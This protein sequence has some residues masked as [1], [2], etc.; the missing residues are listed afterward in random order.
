MRSMTLLA[1]V[2]MTGLVA[3]AEKYEADWASLDRRPTPQWWCDAKFGIFIHW[4]VYAVP[5]Y[6]PTDEASVGQAL[7]AVVAACSGMKIG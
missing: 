2:L 7:R 6:A 3:R 1:L 5:A 4:G